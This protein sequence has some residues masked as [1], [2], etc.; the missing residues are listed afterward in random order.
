MPFIIDEERDMNAPIVVITRAS[1][2]LWRT[3]PFWR[4]VPAISKF[5]L[6]KDAN[7]FSVGVG[8]IPWIYQVTFS[9]WK[10]EEEMI[11]FAHKDKHHG[12]AAKISL[13][14][15]WFK[16]YMFNRFYLVESRGT[17]EGKEMDDLI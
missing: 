3:I 8:E 1:I 13:D 15:N 17:W 7:I 12:E 6:T 2:K 9:I 11:Q 4:R 10:S 16:E 5:I 14:K